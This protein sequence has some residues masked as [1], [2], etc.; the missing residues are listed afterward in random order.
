[1][2]G[3]DSEASALLAGVR[4]LELSQLIAAPL[5]GLQLLDLGAEVVKVEP[6]GGEEG[7]RMPPFA[8]G[9]ESLW[10]HA[11]NRGKRGVVVD[12][13]DAATLRRLVAWADVV[14]E[15]LA[16]AADVSYDDVAAEQPT[17]V[18]CA[19]TGRGAGRGGRAV[20]PSLQ[21]AMGLAA[22]TGEPGGPPL[23][24]PVPVMDF[25][26]AM[27]ATQAVLAALWR[28]ERGGRG[29]LLD[30]ALLDAAATLTGLAGVAALAGEPPRRMGSQSPL[31][32]PSG[33]FATADGHVQ[34]VAYNERQW[35]AICTALDQ[36]GWLEDPHSADPRSRLEHRALV[37]ERL[38]EVLTSG[39]TSHWVDA[40]RTAGG[41]AEPVRD[42]DE[43]WRDGVLRERGLLG[44]LDDPGLGDRPL[45]TLSLTHPRRADPAFPAGPRI[46]EHTA[47]VLAELP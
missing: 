47:A 46:G 1:V 19:I 15:N 16:G 35:R 21:A 41:L 36:P 3:Q 2:T 9:G 18:W 33:F 26:T 39:P 13:G 43:A 4:V 14:V 32:V 22:L 34:V 11:L 12:R 30:V 8:A 44:T 17:L 31:A 5:C 38:A 40:I 23:R 45:P 6:P 42:I 24:V 7:R 20:D 29:G 27:A 28:V 25:M 37:H 10:F